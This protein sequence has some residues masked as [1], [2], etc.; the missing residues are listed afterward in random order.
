M[1]VASVAVVVAI[2]VVAACGHTVAGFGFSLLA[3][4]LLGLVID[5][6]GAV[7]AGSVLLVL[8]SALLA[9]NERAHIDWAAARPLLVGAVPGLPIGLVILEVIPVTALRV[10]LASIALVAVATVGL[11]VR[12]ADGVGPLDYL[13]GFATGVLST[14]VNANGPP[15]VLALQAHGLAPSVFRPTTS[16]VLGLASG[17]GATMF[18]AAG[19]LQGET[20]EV[21]GI[22]IPAVVLGWAIGSRVQRLL[23][24]EVFR[25]LV[26]LL[27][28]AAAVATVV[29]IV[30]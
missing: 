16:A 4:P 8:T 27:M 12:M 19:R 3:V 13:A 7:A 23:P 29:A 5:P 2:A 20:L 9:W 14:T 22:A 30:A 18:L 6:K 25:R 1:S 11:R 24:P 15:T 28:L 10:L 21:T 17:A 26:V